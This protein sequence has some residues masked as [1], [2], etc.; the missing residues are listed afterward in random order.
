M[1]LEIPVGIRPTLVQ[2]VIKVGGFALWLV[3]PFHRLDSF[4]T[5]IAAGRIARSLVHHRLGSLRYTYEQKIVARFG[6]QYEFNLV[7]PDQSAQ[8]QE[9]PN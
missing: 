8:Q 1:A 7:I 6:G 4:V 2:H 3:D 9:A 5:P